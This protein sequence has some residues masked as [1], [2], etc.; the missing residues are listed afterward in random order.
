MRDSLPCG[1]GDN[2]AG[3]TWNDSQSL[4]FL[5][6]IELATSEYLARS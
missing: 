2:S 5:E 1:R 6:H 3:T 4:K